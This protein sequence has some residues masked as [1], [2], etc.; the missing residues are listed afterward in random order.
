VLLR[1]LSLRFARPVC[2]SKINEGNDQGS[3]LIIVH[4]ILKSRCSKV[5]A[6]NSVPILA[7]AVTIA[8]ADADFG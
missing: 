3:Q 5:E 1:L 2:L 7:A 8:A 4:G 6:C